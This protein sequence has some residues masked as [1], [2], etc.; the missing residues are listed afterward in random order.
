[1]SLKQG[2]ICPICFKENLYYLGDRLRQVHQLS[3]SDKKDWFRQAKFC[4]LTPQES[5]SEMMY[6]ETCPYYDIKFHH[7]FRMMVVGPTECRTHFVKQVLTKSCVK[8]LTRK[9]KKIVWFYSQWQSVYQELKSCLGNVITFFEGIPQFSEDLREINP[10]YNNILVFD[11]LMA[12]AVDSPVLSHF[13]SNGA[14]ETLVPFFYY[15]TC[16]PKASIT[17][18]LLAMHNP[19]SCSHLPVIESGSTLE[20]NKSLL[21]TVLK[22]KKFFIQA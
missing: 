4:S 2:R 16:F 20:Q 18:I 13:F 3:G 8:Y 21:K 7:T 11:D 14:I 5:P 1:M 6:R 19:R 15:K 10:K 17:P 12:E 9:P 22:C